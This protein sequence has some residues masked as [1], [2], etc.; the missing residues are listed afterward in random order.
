VRD[1]N[2]RG[3]PALEDDGLLRTGCPDQGGSNTRAGLC[4]TRHPSLNEVE[5]LATRSR[6]QNLVLGLIRAREAEGAVVLGFQSCGE[7]GETLV[8]G[9]EA[10]REGS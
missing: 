9:G 1:V 7:G 5:I 6:G 4:A 2:A 10:L 3:K 8:G